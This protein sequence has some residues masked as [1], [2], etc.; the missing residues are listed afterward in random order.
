MKKIRDWF[1]R[2][3][4]V[5]PEVGRMVDEAEAADVCAAFRIVLPCISAAELLNVLLLA[6]DGGWLRSASRRIYFTLYVSPVSY[7]H[8]DVY[9]RQP[10]ASGT[11]SCAATSGCSARGGR[12]RGAA[13]RSP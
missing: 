12:R 2:V 5:E 10:C 8:L 4:A 1:A 6:L 11:S 13:T 7:T 3:S 9:K